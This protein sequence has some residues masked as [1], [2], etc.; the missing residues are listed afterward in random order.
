MADEP[1]NLTLRIL[2]RIEARL[3][4][5][6][7]RF[8]AID[9]QLAALREDAQRSQNIAFWAL[10]RSEWTMTENAA[11][12]DRLNKLEERADALEGANEDR[13]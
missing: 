9:T 11:Q 4:D 5:Q 1:D 8:D 10:G 3:D 13:T 7:K 2:C 6:D 12:D